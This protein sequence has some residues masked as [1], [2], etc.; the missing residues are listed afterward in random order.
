MKTC[1]LRHK[2]G[3][4]FLQF[5]L[6]F[7][8]F[9]IIPGC[10]T[11]NNAEVVIYTSVDQ[12]YS[13][14]IL[15]QFEKQSGIKVLAVYDVEAAKTTGMVNRLIAEK[16]NP[17]ADIFW[18]G[19]FAQTLLL[20]EKGVL[21]SYK[22]PQAV[23]I[24]EQYLDS[25]GYWTGFSGRAR[26]IIVNTKLLAPGSHPSSIFNFLDN[27]IPAE[28]IGIANPL[29]GT[30]AT[31]ASALYAALGPAKGREYFDQLYKRGIRIVDGNAMVKDMV[32]SGQL[33]AGLTDTD[34]YCSAL[35]DKQ[36]VAAVFPDQ[37]SLGT[38]VIPNTAAMIAGGRHPE[39]AKRLL[40]FL[41]DEKTEQA[42]IDSGWCQVPL[43][44]L[45][46]SLSC[47]PAIKIRMM[48]TG[49]GAIYGQ[50]GASQKE[51]TEIFMK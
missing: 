26:I 21:A 46:T 15:K 12:F 36:P 28:K 41:V 51:L 43:R 48:Q 8:A 45:D 24:P 16:N 22:S 38:L 29:F 2:S 39:E 47:I 4:L 20:K 49:L 40:D 44:P 23:N 27:S 50:L 6:V 18:S 13:E 11:A 7:I 9:F 34:D 37:D 17:R 10:T 32:A 14:P 19:E 33:W 30:T 25:E 42:L 1:S 3:N 5:L 31:H 35:T